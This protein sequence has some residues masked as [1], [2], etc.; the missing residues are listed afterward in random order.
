MRNDEAPTLDESIDLL[1]IASHDDF[2]MARVRAR[3]IR[4]IESV[5]GVIDPIQKIVLAKK[6]DVKEWLVSASATLTN[7]DK[8]LTLDEAKLLGSESYV[9]IM[10]AREKKFRE[11]LEQ[12]EQKVH[13]LSS[14]Q[15]EHVSS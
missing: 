1:S 12:A 2:Q 14:L 7:R 3:A 13:I 10:S 11:L 4:D 9:E 8:P 6:H 5:G 15:V